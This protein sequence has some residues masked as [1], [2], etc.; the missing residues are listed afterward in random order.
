MPWGNEQR[1]QPLPLLIAEWG[2]PNHLPCRREQEGNL[3]QLRCSS[4]YMSAFGSRLM[5]TPK[6]RPPQTLGLLFRR[7]TQ[8]LEQAAHFRHTQP[9]PLVVSSRFFSCACVTTS[10]ACASN[11][12]VMWR[13]QARKPRTSY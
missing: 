8:H 9:D 2:Q 12:S 10:T 7:L 13:Y 1:L 3:R 11:A 5:E 4:R 6:T